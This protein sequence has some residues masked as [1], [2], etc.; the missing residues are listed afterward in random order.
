MDSKFKILGFRFGLDPIIGLIP[1][2]DAIPSVISLY[3]VLVAL[4][5]RLP[6]RIIFKMIINIFTDYLVG[7]I[8]ILGDIFDFGFKANVR[9][10]RML[11]AYRE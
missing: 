7:S 4:N 1:F 11:K 2:F 8:P 6:T 3:L 5:H 9:N 10:I